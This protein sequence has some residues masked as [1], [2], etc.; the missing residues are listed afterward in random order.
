MAA[1]EADVS[2]ETIVPNATVAATNSTGIQF[3]PRCFIIGCRFL[4]AH[5]NIL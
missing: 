3:V 4:C 5:S 2:H 1:R